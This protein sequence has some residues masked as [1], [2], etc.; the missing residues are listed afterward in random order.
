MEYSIFEALATLE[1]WS[2]SALPMPDVLGADQLEVLLTAGRA[3]QTQRL[4]VNVR[5]LTIRQPVG[6]EPVQPG[7]FN[8]TQQ[9]SLSVGQLELEMGVGHT[10][11]RLRE[12]DHRA[13]DAAEKEVVLAVDEPDATFVL[14]APPSR[15]LP[16]RR[17]QLPEPVSPQQDGETAELLLRELGVR[18]SEAKLEASDIPAHNPESVSTTVSDALRRFR[19]ERLE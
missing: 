2:G 12:V 15:R 10:R 6:A 9:F 17:T 5:N 19:F 7:G 8:V 18:A 13:V 4:H 16:P 1:E 11:L 14:S 3:A